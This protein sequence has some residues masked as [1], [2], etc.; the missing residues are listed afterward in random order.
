MKKIIVYLTFFSLLN[1]VGC[2][3]QEQMNPSDYMF[4]E[5]NKVTITT[6]DSIYNLIGDD[7]YRKNDTLFFTSRTKLDAQSTLLTNSEIPIEEI[8]KVEVERTDAVATTLTVVG[9][10]IGVLA[11][12]LVGAMANYP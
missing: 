3:Y 12:L 1:L 2:Y 4:D 6:S 10:I 11:V 5:N 8:E 9:S 7:Y